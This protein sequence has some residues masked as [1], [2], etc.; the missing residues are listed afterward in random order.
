[1]EHTYMHNIHTKI[2]KDFRIFV[3]ITKKS[4]DAKF[5]ICF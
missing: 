3:G 4:S 1:M 5:K 2:N